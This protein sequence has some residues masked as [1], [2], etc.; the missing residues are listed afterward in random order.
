MSDRLLIIGN[1]FDLDLGWKTRYSD[2]AKSDYWPFK[3]DYFNPNAELYP[4]LNNIKNKDLWLDLE[5][6][7]CKYAMPSQDGIIGS[8]HHTPENDKIDYEK[9]VSSLYTYLN[10]ESKKPIKTKSFAAQVLRSVINNGKFKIYSFN[11]SP[12]EQ[13]ASMLVSD[14]SVNVDYVH[15]SLKRD[16]IIL[17]IDDVTDICKGYEYMRKSFNAHYGHHDIYYDLQDA[18]EIVFFGLSLGKIDYPYFSQFFKDQTR[19]EMKRKDSKYIRIFT[20]D[21]NSRI[22]IQNNL[23]KMNEK[24]NL[25][26]K[27]DLEFVLTK[28]EQDTAKLESFVEKMD[29]ES[30]ASDASAYNNMENSLY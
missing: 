18:E 28:D 4:Y 14:S 27:N 22:D 20:Y 9:L 1:G 21:I 23:R 15:G 30:S 10:N 17:G 13:I 29:K 7:L 5:M 3:E 25:F 12:I 6:A 11:Y 26:V 2:F 24:Q 16:D 8:S 19:P